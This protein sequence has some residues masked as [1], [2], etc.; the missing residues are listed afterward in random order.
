M[1]YHAC[2]PSSSNLLD[3]VELNASYF[4]ERFDALAINKLSLD[5]GIT[6]KTIIHSLQYHPDVMS[7]MHLCA[8]VD[9]C[10]GMLSHYKWLSAH[11]HQ[12]MHMCA[13]NKV[14]VCECLST[15]KQIHT[16]VANM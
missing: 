11:M 10:I 12:V 13:L 14:H 9:A 6:T 15:C 8:C 7:Q 3:T 16:H 4:S 1:W 5:T 2:N